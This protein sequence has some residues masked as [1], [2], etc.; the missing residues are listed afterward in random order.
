MFAHVPNC[1]NYS[2]EAGNPGV[3]LKL[4]QN[5][6][7]TERN[8]KGDKSD[9]DNSDGPGDRARVHGSQSLTSD[10]AVNYGETSYGGKVEKYGEAYAV[11]SVEIF[12][13]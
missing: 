3:A 13:Q 12:S 1:N 11:K 4:M 10:D 6:D 8:D 7:T 9:D 5:V 2:N